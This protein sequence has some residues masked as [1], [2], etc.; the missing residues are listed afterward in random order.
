M[1]QGFEQ[2]YIE[3]KELSSVKTESFKQEILRDLYARNLEVKI[4]AEQ[5]E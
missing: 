4:L 3:L 5:R 2:M 1:Q